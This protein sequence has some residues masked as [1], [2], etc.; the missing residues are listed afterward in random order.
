MHPETDFDGQG[1]IDQHPAIPKTSFYLPLQDINLKY[2]FTEFSST[3]VAYLS[4][5]TEDHESINFTELL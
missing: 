2:N 3:R 1:I 5:N 4:D